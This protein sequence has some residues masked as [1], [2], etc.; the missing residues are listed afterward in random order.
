MKRYVSVEG[1]LHE[2][3][4]YSKSSIVTAVTAYGAERG[5]QFKKYTFHPEPN[6]YVNCKTRRYDEMEWSEMATEPLSKFTP[7]KIDLKKKQ[8]EMGNKEEWKNAWKAGWDQGPAQQKSTIEGGTKDMG[9]LMPKM[10]KQPRSGSITGSRVIINPSSTNG[11]YTGTVVGYVPEM[12]EDRYNSQ[13]DVLVCLDE[14]NRH[15]TSYP[16]YTGAGHGCAI[17][18]SNL[19]KL[20]NPKWGQVPEGVGVY[21]PS[22]F[23]HDGVTFRAGEKGR[24]VEFNDTPKKKIGINWN[25]SRGCFGIRKDSQGVRWTNIWFVPRSAVKIGFCESGDL[26]Q[27]MVIWPEDAGGIHEHKFNIGDLVTVP[28]NSVRKQRRSAFTSVRD[29]NDDERSVLPGGTVL[30]IIS[31]SDASGVWRCQILGA[32]DTRL[33][34]TNT[35]VYQ[36]ELTP[37][38]HPERFFRVGQTVEITAEID[39]RV[40]ATSKIITLQGKKGTVVLPTDGDGDVGIEFPEEIGAGSLDGAGAEG[41][42]LYVGASGVKFSE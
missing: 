35:D 39:F 6:S 10:K 22:S 11:G 40:T 27:N 19:T 28:A 20:R 2:I 9:I 32:C 3:P 8:K 41:R 29:S 5:V 12:E 33:I 23:E 7:K 25:K 21:V 37:L 30:E 16:Q 1:Q 36:S 24:I 13:T 34:E 18:R 26:T 31:P 14:Y 42:C 38:S 4:R 15:H 17:G